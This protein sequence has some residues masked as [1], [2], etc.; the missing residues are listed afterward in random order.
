MWRPMERTAD[1]VLRVV[2]YY[3]DH[4]L[5]LWLEHGV[6]VCVNTDNTLLS[7]VSA[8]EE[9]AR[10]RRI[11]GMTDTLLEQVIATGH[12]AAFKARTTLDRA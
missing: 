10:V 2:R 9:L 8:S 5:R 7:D 4:P 3:R 6:Q 12:S 1:G 11:P